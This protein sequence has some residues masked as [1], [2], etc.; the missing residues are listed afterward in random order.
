MMDDA[1]CLQVLLSSGNEICRMLVRR[2][3]ERQLYKRAL[4]IGPDQVNATAYLSGISPEQN[5]ALAG[6]I[7]SRAGVEPQTVLVDIPPFPSDMSMGVRVKNRH[8][9]VSFEEISPRVH[10]LN[11][12]RKEQWRLGVYTVPEQRESVCAAATD[13]LHVKKQTRQDR[14]F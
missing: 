7:A 4:Y 9:V 6:R 13:I 10:T 5:R 2:I 3:Y 14:L 12:T 11:E 8:A 1:A